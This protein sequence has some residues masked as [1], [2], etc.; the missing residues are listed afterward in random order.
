MAERELVQ[1]WRDVGVVDVSG[2][3]LALHVKAA[4]VS[5]VPTPL[6]RARVLRLREGCMQ[7]FGAFR[8]S[9]S[10][11]LYELLL[12]AKHGVIARACFVE[13]GLLIGLLGDFVLPLVAGLSVR[14]A[15][16]L[17]LLICIRLVGGIEAFFFFPGVVE[18]LIA[19]LEHHLTVGRV[20]AHRVPAILFVAGAEARLIDCA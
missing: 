11:L 17:G 9:L 18:L 8:P 13:V 5:L 10:C 15:D 1:H 6:C 2:R 7:L 14:S 3:P 12:L 16:E 19:I 20:K 4:C